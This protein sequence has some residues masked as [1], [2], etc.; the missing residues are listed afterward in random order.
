LRG[1]RGGGGRRTFTAGRDIL[2]SGTVNLACALTDAGVAAELVTHDAR[3][4]AFR[5]QMISPASDDAFKRIAA[6]H[7]RHRRRR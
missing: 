1:R 7:S 3:P 6:F 2:P 4:H 5:A